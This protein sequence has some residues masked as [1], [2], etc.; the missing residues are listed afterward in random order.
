MLSFS[1]YFSYGSR[2]V[3]LGVLRLPFHNKKSETR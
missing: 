2:R 3:P 1:S